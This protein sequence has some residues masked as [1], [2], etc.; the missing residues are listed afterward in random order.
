MNARF[1][2]WWNDDW[3]KLT[4][5][6]GQ[7]VSMFTGGPTDEGFACESQ[8]YSFDADVVECAITTWGRD[9]DGRHEWLGDSSCHVT[10]LKDRE[11]DEHGPAR[12]EWE[13]GHSRQYDQ[14]AEMAGY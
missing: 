14:Y 9:C 3:V 11:A 4:L 8:E 6:P 5:R 10:R 7:S 2:I 13:R 1:W 12:P